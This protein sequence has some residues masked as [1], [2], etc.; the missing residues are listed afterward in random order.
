MFRLLNVEVMKET[1][2]NSKLFKY[3]SGLQHL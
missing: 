2:N 1:Q 3:A